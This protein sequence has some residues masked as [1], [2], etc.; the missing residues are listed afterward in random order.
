MFKFNVNRLAIKEDIIK[1]N[2]NSEV[3]GKGWLS[4]T[5]L[6]KSFLVSFGVIPQNQSSTITNPMSVSLGTTPVLMNTSHVIIT[7]ALANED[8]I[9]P[10]AKSG[11]D[12]AINNKVAVS[13]DLVAQTGESIS[14]TATLTGSVSGV[15]A[16]F[17]CAVDGVW[18]RFS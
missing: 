17:Y 4:F 9:L 7:T 16:R 18:T 15:V 5:K 6:F 12:I 10:K 13:I 1:S 11:L 14:G 2:Y 8:L 3:D